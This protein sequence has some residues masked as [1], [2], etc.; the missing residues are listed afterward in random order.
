MFYT[1][2]PITLVPLDAC[3]DV[4]LQP[5]YD[6]IITA[7]DPAAKFTKQLLYAKTEGPAKENLPLPVF[8]PLAAMIMSDKMK[9][10]YY[11]TLK[12]DIKTIDTPQD[13]M[14]GQT[15]ITRVEEV[16]PIRVALGVSQFEFQEI[17][18]DVFNNPTVPDNQSQMNVGILV[19]DNVETL[20]LAGVFE[21]VGAARMADGK[22]Q[23]N[24]FTIAKDLTPVKTTAGPPVPNSKESFIEIVPN[25]TMD[26]HPKIDILFV[27][28]GQAIDDI[29]TKEKKK[30]FYTEWIKKVEPKAKYVAG[31]C[32]GVM[33]LAL[34]GLLRDQELT[35]HHTR[36]K[37]LHKMSEELGLNLKVMDTRNGKN[38]VHQNFSKY[39]TSGGVHCAIAVAVH[40]VELIQGLPAAESLAYDVMEYTIPRGFNYIPKDFPQ[41]VAMDPQRFIL[42]FSHLNVIV[43]DL[44]MMDEATAFYKR[45]LGFEEAWSLWLP[46]EANQHFAADAGFKDC[47]VLVRFLYHP[48]T[49]MHLELMMYQYPKGCQEVIYHK[50]MMLVV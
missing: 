42:G 7:D 1:D 25:Y 10:T 9:H 13:N 49:Q 28:G 17:W 47:K 24:A 29:L 18:S 20:D 35:T 26:K 30:P 2:I 5:I 41:P 38:Y 44:E 31:C 6:T 46:P 19:F 11:E 12:L 34:T 48:N 37:Q 45:V 8:D 21:A 16:R 27:V 33:L 14:C 22:P 50:P 43:A 40:I 39:M 4:I 23:F 36:F 3:N 15:Y 32:S